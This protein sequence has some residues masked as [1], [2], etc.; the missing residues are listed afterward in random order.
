VAQPRTWQKL[1]YKNNNSTS[2]VMLIQK[3]NTGHVFKSGAGWIAGTFTAI[4]GRVAK[5]AIVALDKKGVWSRIQKPKFIMH[6]FVTHTHVHARVI[7]Q[8]LYFIFVKN[9][10]LKQRYCIHQVRFQ[11][12]TAAL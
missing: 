6:R 11:V 12:S 5:F 3:E 1:M 8:L 9:L 2:E 7:L 10:L 4:I